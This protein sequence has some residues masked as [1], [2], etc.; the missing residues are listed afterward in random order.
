MKSKN[1]EVI[2]VAYNDAGPLLRDR[3]IRFLKALGVKKAKKRAV[4]VEVRDALNQPA[5]KDGGLSAARVIRIELKKV[6]V[7]KFQ[8]LMNNWDAEYAAD[9]EVW[10]NDKPVYFVNDHVDRELCTI[11]GLYNDG[12]LMLEYDSDDSPNIFVYLYR[13]Y[14]AVC[15]DIPSRVIDQFL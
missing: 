6:P 10:T 4:H 14:H 1:E 15:Q 12:F 9:Q 2:A 5:F 8:R 3:T 7:D 13:D 11:Y